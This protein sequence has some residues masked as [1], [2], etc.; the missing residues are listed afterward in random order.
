MCLYILYSRYWCSKYIST[1]YMFYIY[2]TYTYTFVHKSF[3]YIH[4]LYS[5]H[6]TK[7]I[8]LYRNNPLYKHFTIGKSLHFGWDPWTKKRVSYL[9][10]IEGKRDMIFFCA[11]Y[12]SAWQLIVSLLSVILKNIN[13]HNCINI[14]FYHMNRFVWYLSNQCKILLRIKEKEEKIQLYGRT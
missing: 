1:V 9:S 5:E 14:F 13:F 6:K 8:L 4:N 12:N 7:D 10:C 3:C 11:F 2:C